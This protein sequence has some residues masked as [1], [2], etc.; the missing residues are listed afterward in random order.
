N[1]HGTGFH[2]PTGGI[3]KTNDSKA[4][5][6]NL[7]TPTSGNADAGK[8]VFAVAPGEVVTLVGT[9]PGGSSGALLIAHPNAQ[10]PV[11]FSGYLH[12][13]NLRKS[14]GQTVDQSTV[15]GEI[16]HIGA[17]SDHLHFAVYSG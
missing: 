15:V 2:T 1:Q 5:D 12:L 14:A 8:A 7:Y 3:S 17:Q 16:G 11:W 6:I 13:T 9:P 4:W 10:N